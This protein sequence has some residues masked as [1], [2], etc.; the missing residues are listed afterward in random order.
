M[1]KIL[2]HSRSQRVEDVSTRLFYNRSNGIIGQNDYIS[3]DLSITMMN[4][5]TDKFTQKL[6]SIE[7]FKKNVLVRDDVQKVFRYLLSFWEGDN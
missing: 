2:D 1:D 6:N 4:F 7:P 5:V 3:P